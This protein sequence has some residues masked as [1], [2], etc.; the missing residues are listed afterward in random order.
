MFWIFSN[1]KSIL[2]FVSENNSSPMDLF[3]VC[4]F[5]DK[6]PRVFQKFLLNNGQPPPPP[7]PPPLSAGNSL[8]Q[9]TCRQRRYRHCNIAFSLMVVWML[10]NIYGVKLLLV[11]GRSGGHRR[12]T[13]RW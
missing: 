1:E 5:V 8:Y 12:N 4:D 11:N 2:L 7:P 9:L 3:S 10:K 13:W 6:F